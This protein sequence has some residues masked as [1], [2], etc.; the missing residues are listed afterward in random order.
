MLGVLR[1]LLG[2]SLATAPPNLRLPLDHYA[3][4]GFT[5]FSCGRAVKLAGVV[6]LQLSLLRSKLGLL[7]AQSVL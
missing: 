4:A 3:S 1:A 2:T 6:L 5:V 7:P